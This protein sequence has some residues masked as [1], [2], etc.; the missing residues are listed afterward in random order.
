[1]LATWALVCT[2]RARLPDGADWG[3]MAGV[4]L[5]AGI[6]FTMSLFIGGLSFGEGELM[7]EVRLGVLLASAVAALAGF[8]LL[9]SR[10][11]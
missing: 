10:R 8:A 4:A 1:M 2:G 6:G 3:H 7:D 5:L 9:R 11:G